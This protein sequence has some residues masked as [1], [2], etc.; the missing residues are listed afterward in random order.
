MELDS[1]LMQYLLANTAITDIV[2]Q[3]I[4]LLSIPPTED[5]PAIV[6]QR[7]SSPRT[8]G[9]TEP[10]AISPRYQISA[11]TSTNFSGAQEIARV[12]ES[13]LDYFR[14]DLGT[15]AHVVAYRDSQRDSY[16]QETGRYR[17]DIDLII[18][19]KK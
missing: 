1:L 9:L 2:G 12:I 5:T 16:E 13:S 11:Y 14:G 7:I 10:L 19:Y 18:N 15:A 3:N 4:F 6:V 17:S 8:L